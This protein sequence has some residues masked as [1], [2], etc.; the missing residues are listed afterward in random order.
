[1][2]SLG[3]LVWVGLGTA[4]DLVEAVSPGSWVSNYEPGSVLA[5]V[6]PMRFPGMVLLW[7]SVLAVRV[8]HPREVIRAG[9]R[10]LL[11]TPGLLGGAAV[12]PV[13]GVGWLLLSNSDRQVGAVVAS[14]LTQSL[15][16]AAGILL[17][18][19]INRERLLRQ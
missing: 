17:V 11:M 1:V 12:A 2:F 7:Y 15:T 13:V 9:C 10:R 16:V 6:Q 8:P 14:P 4:Y 18:L 5:L 3:F 19:A